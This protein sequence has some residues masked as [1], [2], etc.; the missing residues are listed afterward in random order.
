MLTEHVEPF[1]GDKED[2]N[3]EDFLRS[4]FRRMGMATDD[5]RKQQFQYFLQVD[6]IAD[7]WFDDLQPG[8]KKCWEDI[9]NAFNKHWPRQKAAKKT[10]EEYEEEITGLRLKTE[11]LGKKEKMSGREIYSHIAWADKMGTVVKGAKIETTTTYIGH[12]RKELPKLLREKVGGGY[13]DWMTYLQAIRDID[14][15]YIRDGVD[16]WKKEQDEQE[17]LK[18]RVQMLEKVLAS[19]TAPLRHQM[20][21][22]SIGNPAAGPMQPPWQAITTPANPFTGTTGGRGN[23]FQ[24]TQ[25]ANSQTNNPRPPATAAD[26]AALLIHLQKHP[27][28]PDTEPGRLAHH[29]QQAEWIK[30]HGIGAF[31]TESTPYPL[32]PG[33][34]PVGSGECFT[35]GLSGHMG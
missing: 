24:A 8:E 18:K 5:V 21:T 4:F 1:H 14:I 13:T 34:Q 22:F 33:T 26:R 19:P 17:A 9:E 29:A 27:H 10:K 25:S 31:V 16:I 11:D 2:E 12:D 23:L 35:C 6:S 3:L 32:R 28:H 20:T 15:D 30:T 7:E